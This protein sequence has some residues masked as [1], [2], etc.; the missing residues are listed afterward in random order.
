MRNLS[1]SGLTV[2][3]LNLVALGALGFLGF[4]LYDDANQVI[5]AYQELHAAARGKEDLKALTETLE[6][7]VESRAT[8]TAAWLRSEGLILFIEKLEGLARTAGIELK[9]DEPKATIGEEPRLNLAFA[10]SGSFAGL[11]HFLVLLE[12]LPYRLEWQT[13]SWSSNSGITWSGNFTLAIVSYTD[14][15]A[16]P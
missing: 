7:T 10:G 8:L 11:H 6:G 13:L 15:N 5:I 1:K 3:C 16:I 12:N 14:T 4:K 2:I 9:L